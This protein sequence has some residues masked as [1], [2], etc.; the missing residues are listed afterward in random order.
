VVPE[1][2]YPSASTSLDDSAVVALLDLLGEDPAALTDVLDAFVEE[3]PA[4]LARIDDGVRADDLPS[5]NR[6]AHT[7]K[8][9]AMTFGATALV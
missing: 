7:L 6:A 1:P 4:E 9:N 2:H 8:S 5:V 3:T